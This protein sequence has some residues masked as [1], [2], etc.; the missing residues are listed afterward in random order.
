MWRGGGDYSEDMDTAREAVRAFSDPPIA[1]T[2]RVRWAGNIAQFFSYGE[3]IAVGNSACG[4]RNPEDENLAG[5]D[6][7]TAPEVGRAVDRRVRRAPTCAHSEQKRLCYRARMRIRWEII[8]ALMW[9]VW[10]TGCY[11][12]A[13][14][15][16]L[17]HRSDAE[18]AVAEG[19]TAEDISVLRTSGVLMLEKALRE[20]DL[21]LQRTTDS[22]ER[23]ERWKQAEGF[24]EHGRRW[25]T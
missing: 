19:A 2:R 3:D 15:R 9:T 22:C 1:P 17:E 13:N 24:G 6:V 23:Q 12:Q 10:L 16:S 11:A 20:S 8:L 4:C 7:P 21:I 25:E 18:H 14:K 5:S